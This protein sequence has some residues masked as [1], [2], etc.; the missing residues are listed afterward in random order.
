MNAAPFRNSGFVNGMKRQLG[1]T[2]ILGICV[3][4]LCVVWG[5]TLFGGDDKAAKPSPNA[6][7]NIPVSKSAG[8]TKSKATLASNITAANSTG[9]EIKSFQGAVNRLD[10]WRVPLGMEKAE[11]LTPA[12]IA[13]HR[14]EA[15]RAA[16]ARFAL[17]G[18]ARDARARAEAG[19][20]F[21]NLGNEILANGFSE[22]GGSTPEVVDQIE[23]TDLVL[24][25]T[26]ILGSLHLAFFGDQRIQEG[27]K[28]GRYLVKTV[29]PREV[30]IW[31]E[32]RLTVLRMAPP[33]LEFNEQ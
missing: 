17:T 12:I 7:A 23:I 6:T 16:E 31:A 3:V 11:T 24:T 27:G 13:L 1:K 10:Q 8:G 14:A 2:A 22:I 18:S 21:E 20:D 33:D 5:P 25:G 29:R 4:M 19:E 26:A 9:N 30:D 32:G 28:I 15:Q